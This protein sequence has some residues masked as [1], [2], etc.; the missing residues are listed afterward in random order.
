MGILFS[1]LTSIVGIIAS[2][3]GA[4]FFNAILPLFC[5]L[6]TSFT[7]ICWLVYGGFSD[8][9][10]CGPMDQLNASFGLQVSA[11]GLSFLASV[12]TIGMHWTFGG[13]GMSHSS[14]AVISIQNQINKDVKSIEPEGQLVLSEAA[15][16]P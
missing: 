4:R 13:F 1:G 3:T 12:A 16:I 11:F 14:N 8:D 2:A 10:R 5:A 9:I 6:T 15:N 7:M